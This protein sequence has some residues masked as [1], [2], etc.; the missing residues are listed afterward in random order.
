MGLFLS[1]VAATTTIKKWSNVQPED[2]DEDESSGD[3][4]DESSSDSSDKPPRKTAR[5]STLRVD[6]NDSMP[7][8]KEH[9]L[10]YYGGT[11]EWDAAPA[12]QPDL[13]PASIG[14]TGKKRKRSRSRRTF[15]VPEGFEQDIDSLIL[16]VNQSYDSVRATT[17]PGIKLINT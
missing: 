6:P 8:S 14:A 12:Y 5:G 2:K 4:E 1:P 13:S 11:E 17:D 15:V 7:H 10:D 16:Q 9:F 3:D